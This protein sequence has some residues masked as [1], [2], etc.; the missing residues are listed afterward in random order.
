[1]FKLPGGKQRQIKLNRLKCTVC[2]KHHIELPDFLVPFKQYTTEVI[3]GVIDG[4]ITTEEPPTED[5][6]CEESMNHWKW[7]FLYNRENI[8]GQIRTGAYT[9][10][11]MSPEFL[12]SSVSLLDELRRRIPKG[13]LKTVISFI[14]NT[15][16]RI[17]VNPA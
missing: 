6:P 9:L 8:E 5:Y 15:G 10:L 17:E 7:W 3:E 4:R 1:M 2:N 12:K 13:W 11:D 16:G 14:Y